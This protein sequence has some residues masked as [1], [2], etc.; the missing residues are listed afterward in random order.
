[1]VKLTNGDLK[2][3]LA[4]VPEWSE[5]SG[6]IQRTYQFADFVS[7]MAFV[8]GAAFAAERAQHH[9]EIM[10]RYNKVTLTLSTHDAGA[11]TEKD[12]NLAKT[13][14]GIYA[15]TGG[16]TKVEQAIDA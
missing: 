7:A 10:I 4:E 8:T 11:I 3:A 14:D 6:T 12:F 1:M 2:A 9:P 16:S 15:V 13:L 5:V